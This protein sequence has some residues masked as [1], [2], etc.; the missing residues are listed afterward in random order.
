[1]TTLEFDVFGEDIAARH[2]LETAARSQD[3]RPASRE[4]RNLLT[5]GNAAQF[6]SKGAFFGSSWPP[7]AAATLERKQGGE[8]GVRTGALKASLEGGRGRTT[9]ATKTQ[10]KVG[11][12]VW[13]ARM[14]AGGT[15][16][17]QPARQLVGATAAQIREANL[18][19]RRY[20]TEGLV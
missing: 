15:K 17:G 20:V 13:Y 6:S 3:L 18:I 14:F 12:K 9:S 19:I 1:M 8:I 16:T 5:K 11:T 4:I 2:L 7:L 10:V